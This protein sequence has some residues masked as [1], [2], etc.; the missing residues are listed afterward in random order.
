MPQYIMV[1][2]DEISTQDGVTALIGCFI[3]MTFPETVFTSVTQ[4]YSNNRILVI[5][6]RIQILNFLGTNIFDIHI[7][8]SYKEEI[9]SIFI[10][11][12]VTKNKY[13]PY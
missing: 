10:F 1:L 2:T 8:P 4:I 7:R 5:N 9:Y 6:I 11:G 12:Q 3:F 13:I